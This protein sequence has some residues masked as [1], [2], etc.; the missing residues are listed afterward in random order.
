ML[1]RSM[2]VQ[3]YVI[4]A[5]EQQNLKWEIKA[6]ARKA[7]GRL[8]RLERSEAVKRLHKKVEY[9]E[10]HLDEGILD[11]NIYPY[12][13]M[14]P[15]KF[16]PIF[17]WLNKECLIFL[18]EPLRLKEQLDFQH[19]QR[20]AEFTE[21]L[22]KGEEFINPEN[23]YIEFDEMVSGGGRQ[24]IGMSNLLREIQGFKP[25]KVTNMTARPLAGYKKTSV[26]VDEIEH[27]RKTGYAIT[28]FAGT[29]EHAVRLVQGLKDRGIT[30][31][32]ADLKDNIMPGNVHIFDNSLDQGFE[33]P[34]SKLVVLD[35]KSVV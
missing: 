25:R 28:L 29:A 12:L 15:E 7:V 17:D 1:F 35:R 23:L 13:S 34:L 22:E 20:L 33:L 21:N 3:E 2:P 14:F 9:I 32:L 6:R 31:S 19:N 18:D 30:A 11:E 8:Q 4:S 27:W 24:I 5:E 26:L 16:V 10:D